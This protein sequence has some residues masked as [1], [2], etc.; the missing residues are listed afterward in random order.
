[1]NHL[2]LYPIVLLLII[3]RLPDLTG[4]GMARTEERGYALYQQLNGIYLYILLYFCAEN[5]DSY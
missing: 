1:M 2:I 4:N 5:W 3:N